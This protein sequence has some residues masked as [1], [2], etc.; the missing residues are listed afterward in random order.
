MKQKINRKKRQKEEFLEMAHDKELKI[1]TEM[2]IIRLTRQ[3]AEP[4]FV[5]KYLCTL[6]PFDENSA[7]FSDV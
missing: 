4:A 3:Q 7:I 1:E 6:L 5:I 2:D